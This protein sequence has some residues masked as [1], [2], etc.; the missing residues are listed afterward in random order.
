MQ[1][2]ALALVLALTSTGAPLVDGV[3]AVPPNAYECPALPGDGAGDDGQ[4]PRWD[5]PLPSVVTRWTQLVCDAFNA[6]CAPWVVDDALHIIACE[7]V[8][9][10]DAYNGVTGVTGLFQMH[11]GW[12]DKLDDLG[13][14]G[15]QRVR[16]ARQR[17]PRR[18]AV[19]GNG[20]VV[21]L[22]LQTV[23]GADPWLIILMAVLTFLLVIVIGVV[24]SLWRHEDHE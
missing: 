20:R 14:S 17:R 19:E 4:G 13:Y 22:G 16:P 24:I 18:L 10:P 23:N 1:V 7:S 9:D 8:G 3:R 12:L 21:P 5:A 11:P 6:T 2:T 15:C